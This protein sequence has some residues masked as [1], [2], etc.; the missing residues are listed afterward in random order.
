MS[1][2]IYIYIC[3][4]INIKYLVNYFFIT[5]LIF[6]VCKIIKR[7]I[8]CKKNYKIPFKKGDFARGDFV[9]KNKSLKK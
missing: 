3:V 2:Y 5:T 9:S 7:I 6:F 1:I 4:R 8:L